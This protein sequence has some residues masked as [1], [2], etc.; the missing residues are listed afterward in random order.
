M[1]SIRIEDDFPSEDD[2][3]RDLIEHEIKELEKE[4]RGLRCPTHGTSPKLSVKRRGKA[5]PEISVEVCCEE[6]MSLVEARF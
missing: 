4:M 5:E 6:L 2:L 1:F 3:R